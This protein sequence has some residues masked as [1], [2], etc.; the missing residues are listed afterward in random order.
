MNKKGV[1]IKAAFFAIVAVSLVVLAVGTN[2][3]EWSVPYS[4]NLT[5]D[6]NE[7]SDLRGFSDEAQN[8]RNQTT[9]TDA[10]PG[11]GDLEGKL[12]R[13]GYG[14][15]GN[16]F[17]SFKVVF[18]MFDSIEKRFGLP[19]YLIEG[20]LTLMTFSLVFA[21]ATVLFRLGRNP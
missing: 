1:Q 8:Q 18:A 19:S 3:G 7:Y 2:I 9:P 17:R 6:L 11:T 12:L 13:G 21:I 15:I 14:I 5:Y 4:S 20:L 16:V 10:D